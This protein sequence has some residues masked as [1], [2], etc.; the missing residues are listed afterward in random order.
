MA[1]PIPSHGRIFNSI[2]D[3]IGNTPLVRLNNLAKETGCKA[4][5]VGKLEFFNPIGSVKDR[6]GAS[7]IEAME[8]AG[9]ITPGKTTLI[10]PTS[11]TPASRWLSLPPPRATA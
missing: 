8:E 3:T 10:E 2:L 1:N 6:I 4:S 5:L 11:A 9:T 7:M